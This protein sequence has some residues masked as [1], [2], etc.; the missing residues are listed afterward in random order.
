[1]LFPEVFERSL[2]QKTNTHVSH[3]RR[4]LVLIKLT[5]KVVCDW[6]KPF[7]FVLG[8]MEKKTIHTLDSDLKQNNH[9]FRGTLITLM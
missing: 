3:V 2:T 4:H 7:V 1:M 9:K 6:L 8:K 5:S